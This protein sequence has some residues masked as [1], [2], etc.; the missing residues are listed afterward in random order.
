M[1]KRDLILESLEAHYLRRRIKLTIIISAITLFVVNMFFVIMFLSI[2]EELIGILSVVNILLLPIFIAFLIYYKLRLKSFIEQSDRYILSYA[3]LSEMHYHYYLKREHF[4]FTVNVTDKN[5]DNHK[6]DT[7]DIFSTIFLPRFEDWQNLEV[8]VAYDP[9]Q[10]K[11]FVIG[12]RED[13]ADVDIYF[14]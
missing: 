3:F 5:G 4:Y 13:F 9:E 14:T 11:A 6:A 12:A 7:T 8:L 2:P 1:N 10:G